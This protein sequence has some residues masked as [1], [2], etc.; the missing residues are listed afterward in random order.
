MEKLLKVI[1]TTIEFGW[2]WL[3]DEGNEIYLICFGYAGSIVL[4]L[5]GVRQPEFYYL[6]AAFLT[7]FLLQ[8]NKNMIKR[9]ILKLKLQKA[10]ADKLVGYQ[11][12][13]TRLFACASRKII[14]IERCLAR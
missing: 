11:S 5:Y 2:L 4:I 9:I 3:M 8:H 6:G 12:Q 7:A 1:F 14:V 13:N 10:K